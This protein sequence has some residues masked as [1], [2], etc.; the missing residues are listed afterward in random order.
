MGLF[1]DEEALLAA[2]TFPIPP[3]ELVARAKRILAKGV[4]RCQDQLAQ[5]FNFSAPFIGPLGKKAFA[6]TMEELGLEQ[7]FPDLQPRI[8]DVRVDPLEPNRVW[9]T[10]RPVGRQM[11]YLRARSF[12]PLP[13]SGKLV[14]SP[15][16]TSSLVFNKQ[17]LVVAFTLGYVMD[18]RVGNTG[19]L[20]GAFGMLWAIGVPFPYPEGKPW[21]SSWQQRLF[22]RGGALFQAAAFVADRLM[23][24]LLPSRM[25]T[26]HL[27]NSS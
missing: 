22:N 1:L 26:A 7:A 21:E 16:Q 6:S 10:T 11:G 13:P 5:D 18:R 25:T 27:R 4:H 2:S 3:A 12:A 14:E 24:G 9:L 20:G 15:P 8:Y 19:G 17:G 23:G